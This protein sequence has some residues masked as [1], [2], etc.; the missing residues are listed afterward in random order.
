MAHTA[1]VSTLGLTLNNASLKL[2]EKVCLNFEVQT[3]LEK[4][5]GKQNFQRKS[6]LLSFLLMV[7]L[8]SESQDGLC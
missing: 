1:R 8:L 4:V 5:K 6:L 2:V 3:N 7:Y